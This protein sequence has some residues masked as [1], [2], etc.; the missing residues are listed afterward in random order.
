M[1]TPS[2]NY[3]D[4]MIGDWI[5]V[6]GTFID[7]FGVIVIVSGIVWATACFLK[8]HLG[9]Q[10]Y[11]VYKIRI[12]RALLLGLE[13]LVA[14]DIVKTIAIKPTFVSLGVLAGLVVVRTFLSWTLTLEID[15]R[16]PWQGRLRTSSERQIQSIPQAKGR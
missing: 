12:G 16:W 14:A 6:V 4:I 10:Q 3:P 1:E 9:E 13:L 5:N 8:H 15:G 2:S 7:L 11:E